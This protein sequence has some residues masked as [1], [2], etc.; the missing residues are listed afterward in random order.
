MTSTG[1]NTEIAQ[2]TDRRSFFLI[3]I[4]GLWGLIAMALAAPAALYLLLPPRV[5]KEPEW[6]D[7]GDVSQLQPGTPVEMVFRRNRVDGWKLVSEKSTAWVVKTADQNVIAFAPQ[8]THLG[9]A[10]HWDEQKDQFLCPCHSST[11]ALD[12]KVLSGPAPRPLDRYE[13]K[14]QNSKLLLGPIRESMEP[15]E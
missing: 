8:C 9:C 6:A 14:V 7:A 11:F 4:Y 12:G 1:L 13:N 2:P 3:T 10:Y 15:T 5:R